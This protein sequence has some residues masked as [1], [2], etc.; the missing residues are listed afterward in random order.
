LFIFHIQDVQ[1]EETPR[2]RQKHDDNGINETVNK[3][4]V[5]NDASDS[6]DDSD[7]D[8]DD[9]DFEDGVEEEQ[10]LPIS[11]EIRLKDHHR[12][13]SALSLEPSGSRLISGSYDYDVKFWDF[14]GMDASY[15]PFRSIEPCGSHKIHDLHYS[16]TGDS[17]LIISGAARAKLFDRDGY[18]IT[19]YAKGDPYIRDLR[20]TDGHISGLT[21]GA[22][23]P[24]DRNTFITAAQD[25]T[26][27]IWDVENK[28]KQKEVIL[29][30][31]KERGGRTI[32]TTTAYSKDGK[33]IVG[34][35]QDGTLNVWSSTGPHVRP[36]HTLE[37]AHAVGTETSSAVFSM[38]N[39]TLV[40]RGGDDT[41]K[42][43]YRKA[44]TWLCICSCRLTRRFDIQYGIS[45][46]SK[47]LCQWPVTL[48]QLIQ[49]QT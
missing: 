18:E 40:T 38:D 2:K 19:E 21:S 14:A 42:G 6:D 25:S 1:L 10:E 5:T 46:T 31:S 28:R 41:V 43:T 32:V 47:N 39:H 35:C 9:D 4:E 30:K 26:I 24:H 16:I 15:R 8:S 37:N 17:F 27:R 45:V 22:W 44:M 3:P 49:R 23:H 12:T 34:A 13:V 11:H 33:L 48:P 7:E 20:K 29:Y 36:T